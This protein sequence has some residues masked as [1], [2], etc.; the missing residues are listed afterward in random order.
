MSCSVPLCSAL[1]AL[2]AHSIFLL[3][4]PFASL[5]PWSTIPRAVD[6]EL[7]W[8]A[9]VRRGLYVG[10]FLSIRNPWLRDMGITG[11]VDCSNLPLPPGREDSGLAVLRIAVHDDEHARLSDHFDKV[12]EFMARHEGG[13]TVACA[14]GVSRSCAVVA[15][16]LVA[17]KGSTLREAM[18]EI[19]ECRPVVRPNR[20]FLTQLMALE[21]QIRGER[22]ATVYELDRV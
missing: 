14:A 6:E 7:V 8:P 5:L 21:Q 19:R 22:S 1:A 2:S 13:C 17:R 9:R 12:F 4:E 18:R 16:W 15:G 11:I 10:D 20:G 3:S